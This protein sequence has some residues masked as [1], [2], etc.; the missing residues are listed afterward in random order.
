MTEKQRRERA[1]R[2]RTARRKTVET[3]NFVLCVFY[4]SLKIDKDSKEAL[5]K[6]MKNLK[7]SGPRVFTVCRPS[8]GRQHVR[9]SR[10]RHLTRMPPKT[11]TVKS[12]S[13]F[14]DLLPQV[15]FPG[16]D[17][18]LRLGRRGDNRG[19]YAP[20]APAR[21]RPVR[22]GLCGWISGNKIKTARPGGGR[23]RLWQTGRE[24][25]AEEGRPRW[26]GSRGPRLRRPAGGNKRA[27]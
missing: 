23:R 14:P 13:R 25:T 24:G 16:A 20:R 2:P 3:V 10:R 4:H 12:P 5:S 11:A 17:G 15:K 7:D 21:L 27:G 1:L 6:L 22:S 18:I 9:K 19:R 8:P 26:T